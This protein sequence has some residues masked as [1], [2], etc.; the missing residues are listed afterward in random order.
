MKTITIDQKRS[1]LV[2]EHVMEIQSKK[3]A[4]DYGRLALSAPTMLRRAGLMQALAFFEAKGSR[5]AK[6]DQG[7]AEQTGKTH[8]RELVERWLVELIALGRVPDGTTSLRGYAETC[9][10]VEYMRLTREVLA[11]AQWHRRFAQSVL[12]VEPGED[13][14]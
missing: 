2:F 6:A 4:L 5:P 12:K 13:V 9:C 8:Y 3:Y 7:E 14:Q 10:L 1:K 11:L